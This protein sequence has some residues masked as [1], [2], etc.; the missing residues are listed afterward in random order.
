VKHKAVV[1]NRRERYT[2]GFIEDTGKYY[3]SIMVS[4]R[5][6]DYDEYYEIDRDEFDRYCADPVSAFAFVKRCRRR[7]EDDRLIY[8]PGPERGGA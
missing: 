8:Q 6:V 7:E 4:N 2:L 1:A 3:A 5:M